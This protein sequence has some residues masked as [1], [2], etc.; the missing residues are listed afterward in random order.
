ME[1]LFSECSD[2]LIFHVSVLVVCV[3]KELCIVY[4]SELRIAICSGTEA[5]PRKKGTAASA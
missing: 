5:A 3:V 1:N 2:L 4:V